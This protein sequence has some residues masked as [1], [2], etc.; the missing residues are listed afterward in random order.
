MP[1]PPVHPQERVE[2]KKFINGALTTFLGT[3]A[4]IGAFYLPKHPQQMKS[5][6]HGLVV[7]GTF[8][9]YK[10]VAQGTAAAGRWDDIVKEQSR[11]MS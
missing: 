4:V 9:I 2:M 6:E 5:L 7:A 11:K 8:I 10:G 1:A 3:A